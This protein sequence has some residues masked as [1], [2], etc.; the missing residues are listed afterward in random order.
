[1]SFLQASLGN[2]RRSFSMQALAVQ[3]KHVTPKHK[4]RD[5]RE[6]SKLVKDRHHVWGFSCL[7]DK[8]VISAKLVSVL[9]I[10]AGS[11][12][13]IP[14]STDV[15]YLSQSALKAFAAIVALKKCRLWNS[16]E[17]FFFPQARAHQLIKRIAYPQVARFNF[18]HVT[19]NFKSIM[20]SHMSLDWPFHGRSNCDC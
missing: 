4:T 17:S 16:A 5:S 2:N 15:F 12:A 6:Q 20:G 1:M 14:L 18:L 9:A 8:S 3:S 7:W 13:R 19:G 10:N 11:Q